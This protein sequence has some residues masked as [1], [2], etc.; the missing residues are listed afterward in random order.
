ML[1][2]VRE[3]RKHAEEIDSIYTIYVVDDND[4]LV[5]LVS[6]KKILTTTL[7]TPIKDVY[8]TDVITVRTN[9][10]KEEVAKVME[11]YDL[12]YVP[13]ID[14]LGRLCGRITIDDVVDVIREEETE[15]AQKMSAIETFDEPYMNISL[16]GIFKKRVWWLIILFIGESLTAIAIGFFEKEIAKAVIL[17]SFIPLI[18]SSGGN[19]GSQVSTLV[20]RAL[21]LG[22]V[23]VDEWWKIL[24]REI[25]VGF[26]LGLVLGLVGF[27]RVAAWSS[28]TGVY[29]EHS[30]YVGACVGVSLMGVVLWGNLIGSLFPLI[31]KRVGFDPA[32]SSA[33]FV[34]TLV[35]VTGLIIYFTVASLMLT[36]ILL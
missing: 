14:S 16:F 22:E 4:K 8:E 7:R 1:T 9:T 23:T 17:V 26:F 6:F 30:M 13:V 35:D 28:L 25:K 18:I 2:C 34:A 33:P 24:S 29:G 36:G 15:D 11:K 19:T 5:G 21:S 3:L 27:L 31:L 20:I 32:V 10:D 12:V